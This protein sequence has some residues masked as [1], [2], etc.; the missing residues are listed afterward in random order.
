ML[1]LRTMTDADVPLGMA[2]KQA[3]G[4]NQ[5]IADWKRFL[6][7]TPGGCFV[8]EL[9]GK[10]VGTVVTAIFGP[11]AWVAMVLVDPITRGK[12]VGTALMS[13]ALKFLDDRRV[14][15]VRL[16]ATP[17]GQPI[18]EK[19]GFKP[20]FQLHR[21]D[22]LLPKMAVVPGVKSRET[23]G[24]AKHPGASTGVSV[25]TNADVPG[26]LALDRALSATPREAL[27]RRLIADNPTSAAVVRAN[28]GVRGY[29]LSRPGSNA[30]FI[31][32][33]MASDDQAGNALLTWAA[34]KHAGERVFVDIPADNAPA[35]AWAASMGLKVQR[36]LLRMSRGPLVG[37]KAS[38]VWASSGP[39]MG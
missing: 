20:E 25:L 39:E 37:E 14:P 11:V 33:V 21:L 8:A 29:A 2:L 26:V 19:L 6:A 10:G 38:D 9:D 32:P 24:E 28:D 13:H 34:M 30:T 23:S 27:I 4:W 12:G 15:T 7:I 16:D 1:H 31:G 17:L 5:T 22:G 35:R 36:P 18:Y 3:A